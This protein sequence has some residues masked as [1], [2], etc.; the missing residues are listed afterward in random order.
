MIPEKN[1]KVKEFFKMNLTELEN[2]YFNEELENDGIWKHFDDLKETL[3]KYKAGIITDEETDDAIIGC[4]YEF[5]KRALKWT[6]NQFID[7]YKRIIQEKD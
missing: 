2:E 4:I 6:Y 3:K 1:K 5:E 7:E